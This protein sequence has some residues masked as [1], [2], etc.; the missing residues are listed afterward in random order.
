MV[1][2]TILLLPTSI[3]VCAFDGWM[4]GGGEDGG[5]EIESRVDE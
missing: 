1:L 3:M 4:D 2:D 5:K